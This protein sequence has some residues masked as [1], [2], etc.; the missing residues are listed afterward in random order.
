LTSTS[1][2]LFAAL[3]ALRFFEAAFGMTQFDE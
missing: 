1:V 2:A 3:A